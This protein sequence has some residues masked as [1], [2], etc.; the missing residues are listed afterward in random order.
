M[1]SRSRDRTTDPMRDGLDIAWD[2]RR[3][4]HAWIVEHPKATMEQIAA[5]HSHRPHHTI[6]VV[7][8]YLRRHGCVVMHGGST[9]SRY[10]H[11]A[12][13]TIDRNQ[14]RDKMRSGGRA[15][16]AANGRKNMAKPKPATL[17]EQ[18][19]R[20]RN[21]PDINPAIPNQRGQ[22]AT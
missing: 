18:P 13:F 14:S 20:Y 21:R 17:Q 12:P 19:G 4:V 2:L 6:R 3:A 11:S 5:A 10:S 9:A 16:G 1:P 7:V 8:A 15:T 22:G